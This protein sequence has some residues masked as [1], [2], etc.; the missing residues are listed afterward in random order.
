[1]AD[2]PAPAE[3]PNL[4]YGVKV[5]AFVLMGMGLMAVGSP[6][7]GVPALMIGKAK[8]PGDPGGRYEPDTPMPDENIILFF[9]TS[10]GLDRFIEALEDLR[11]NANWALVPIEAIDD[12][13]AEQRAGARTDLS[14]GATEGSA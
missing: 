3:D 13:V 1:M 10:A 11:L 5:S 2:D 12:L 7:D 9:A 14:S 6:S 8:R 4:F